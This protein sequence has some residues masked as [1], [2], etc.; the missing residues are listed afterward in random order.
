VPSGP[1]QQEVIRSALG[2]AGIAPAEVGY[3]EAHGTGTALGD[4]IEVA[5]IDAVLGSG[6]GPRKAK[7]AL[8]SVKSRLGHLEAAAGIAG[9]IKLAL[10]L[11]QGEV[12][13]ALSE[14][15]GELNKLIPWHEMQV[16]VPR[17]IARW[18]K[19]L[20]RKIA[21]ISAFGLSGTN[22]HAVF[23]SYDAPAVPKANAGT[24]ELLTLSAK[25][26]NAL[27]ALVQ[28]T[29]QYLSK[30][31]EERVASAC[32]TA[33]AGRAAHRHR[34]G[35]VGASKRELLDKLTAALSAELEG[36]A[37]GAVLSTSLR[38]AANEAAIEASMS[39]LSAMFP[40]IA[41]LAGATPR[42]RLEA[43]LVELGIRSKT[44]VDDSLSAVAAQLEWGNLIVP[45]IGH[46]P[47]EAPALLLEALASLYTAGADV[48][49]NLLAS[50]GA[51]LLADA[52]TYP[53]QRK[54]YWIDEPD[55]E[56]PHVA[57]VRPIKSVSDVA[58]SAHAPAEVEAYLL[59]ELTDVLRA[60][61][62]LDCTQ[63]FLAVGGDSFMAMM[64][65]RSVEQTYNVEI[66]L[67]DL[68]TDL[69]L[70]ELLRRL[71]GHV[72]RVSSEGASPQEQTA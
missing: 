67:E 23:E 42:A 9:I 54:R 53:F 49:F 38:L 72:L 35:V 41:R 52:P 30:L 70:S 65:K 69:P 4:P 24:P 40:G 20:D 28:S 51:R 15:D 60:E 32:H 18:P 11:Q 2:D 3:V 14:S 59:R 71:S 13:A 63:T 17:R 22:A 64:L 1:A 16:Q 5:A 25:D 36:R 62:E 46:T 10:M 39:V 48:R 7:V 29:S 33:R 6:A 19:A 43:M 61:G 56:Q 47:S 68:S 31:S 21:G 27:R 44:T 55:A 12:P 34:V 8:G 57:T 45:V 58:P 26:P 50:E 66:P 37:N